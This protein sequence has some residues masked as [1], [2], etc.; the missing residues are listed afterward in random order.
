MN[1]FNLI[2]PVYDRLARLVFGDALI[3]AQMHYY[4]VLKDG[5]EVLIVGGGTGHVLKVLDQLSIPLYVTYLDKSEKMIN[6]SKSRAPFQNI[7]VKYFHA[8]LNT[9]GHIHFDVVLVAFFLDVFNQENLVKVINR[10]NQ[11]LKKEGALLVTDF[12]NTSKGW[13]KLLI[14]FMYLFF[15]LTTRLEGNRLLDFEFYLKRRGFI[16][17]T[18]RS[19]FHGLIESAIYRKE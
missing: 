14:G 16:K 18:C 13:H 2:A 6:L 8:E 7:E 17:D 5:D 15:R 1:N 4:G 19:F 10:L 3:N 9:I 12:V 11:L